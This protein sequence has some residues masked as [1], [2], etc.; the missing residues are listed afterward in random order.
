MVS[1][2]PESTGFLDLLKGSM[3]P[4]RDQANI[5]RFLAWCVTWA[6]VF[7]GVDWS[8]ENL[9][10]AP[11]AA[12][13]IALIPTLILCGALWAYLR[14]LREA[15]ELIRRIQLEGVALGFGVGIIFLMARISLEDAG[16]STLDANDAAVVMM[17]SWC[18][19]QLFAAW[20]YR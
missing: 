2:P 9:D 12:S 17:L 3:G 10:V 18:A 6:I 20:R 15:D 19:G 13:V 14:Y 1:E 8:L 16:F 4:P 7:T 11:S 5:R